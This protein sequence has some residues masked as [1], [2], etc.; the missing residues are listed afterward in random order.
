MVNFNHWLTS[1]LIT[2][3]L[4]LLSNVFWLGFS[5]LR[6]GLGFNEKELGLISQNWNQNLT[7]NITKQ[8]FIPAQHYYSRPYGKFIEQQFKY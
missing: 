3:F 7:G 4:F 2:S 5:G 6:L 1:A 8:Q